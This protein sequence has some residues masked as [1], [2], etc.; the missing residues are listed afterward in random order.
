MKN[1]FIFLSV[2][3]F[4]VAMTGCENNNGDDSNAL[5][6][7][8][9]AGGPNYDLRGSIYYSVNLM[10]DYDNYTPGLTATVDIISGNGG[11]TIEPHT[12][13]FHRADAEH[14]SIE[15]SFTI[16]EEFVKARIEGNTITFEKVK[17]IG[18]IALYGS[19]AVSDSRGKV[20]YCH[21]STDFWIGNM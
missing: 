8:L 5:P 18:N 16:S 9:S 19:Y 2:I 20:V 13:T 4:A 11:Y 6:L 1:I 17:N 7:V 12:V 15:H 21:V 14:G 10:E 3:S